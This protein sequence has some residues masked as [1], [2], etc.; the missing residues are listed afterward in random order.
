MRMKRAFDPATV[1]RTRGLATLQWW[2][3]PLVLLI[4]VVV[5]A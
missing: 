4:A 5:F 3:Q 1:P 2:L